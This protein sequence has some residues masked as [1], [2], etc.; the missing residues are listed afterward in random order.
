MKLSPNYMRKRVYNIT[1][2]ELKNN[3][4]EA[5]ILDVDNT[6]TTHDNPAPD[7]N[8]AAWLDEMRKN[9]IKMII[10]SNN[11]E[12]RVRPFAK[13]LGLEFISRGNKPLTGGIERCCKEMGSNKNNTA[14]IGDQIFTDIWGGNRFGCITYLVSPIEAENKPFFKFKRKC[15]SVLLRNKTFE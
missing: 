2:D 7:E 13:I 12:E 10:L 8:V 1:V 3:G 9:H 14:V 11:S 5:L 6:L 4:I 15:E